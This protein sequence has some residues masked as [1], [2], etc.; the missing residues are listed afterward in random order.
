M[1]EK[2]RERERKREKDKE[3]EREE[4]KRERREK[5]REREKES[6]YRQT[7]HAQS[8]IMQ[9]ENYIVR[10]FYEIFHKFVK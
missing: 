6:C 4:R 1:R 8:K 3:R 10:A 9:I 2:E 5:V 7:F